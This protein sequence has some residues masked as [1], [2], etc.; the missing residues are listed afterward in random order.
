[1]PKRVKIT[2]NPFVKNRYFG[3]KIVK[4]F[5][6]L[7]FVFLVL[8]I[9]LSGCTGPKV[10]LI[11]HNGKVYTVDKPFSVM[12][13][14]AIRDGKIIATGTSTEI[15]H[16]YAATSIIDLEGKYVYPG[17]I[18]AHSHFFGYASD[19]LKCD[20]TGTRSYTELLEKLSLFSKENKFEWLLGRGWDQNDWEDTGYPD[21]TELDSLFPQQ[22]VFLM[23]IDG[24]AALCNSAALRRANITSSTKITGGEIVLKDG[25]PTGLLIDN[26]VDL[27]K[28]VIPP[29]S[30]ALNSDALLTAQENCFR[31]GLTSVCDAGLGKDSIELIRR[32]Q[33]KDR[34]KIRVYAMISD[35]KKSRDYYFKKGPILTDRLTVRAIKLYADGAL[36]SRG[37]LLKQPY[38]DQ[39]EH[40]GFLLHDVAYMNNLADEALEHGFQLCTHAIGDSAIRLMLDIFRE[41]LL[42]TNNRRWRLEHCQVVDPKD[43]GDFKKLSVIPSVQPTHATSDMYWAGSRLGDDRLKTAYCFKD[44]LKQSDRLA[45]GTDF[46]VERIDPLLT[47]YAA[48]ARKDTSGFP[49][50]GFLPENKIKRKDALR[51]M[52]IWAAY[53]NFEDLKKGSIEVGKYA[54]LV[55]LDQDILEC[56]EDQLLSTQVVA[57]YVDGE[58]LYRR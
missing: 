47:F 20:L 29:F 56:E 37:A 5:R 38:S 14:V 24:H 54:D 22:P 23:R 49:E 7:F 12:E 36:G 33:K 6:S 55:I 16:R 34:L 45:F 46:P 27:V 52:T 17:F 19:L 25:Q 9:V 58:L 39:P 51:A 10:D 28:E 35:T 2:N 11:L 32:L 15:L 57:T 40:Y 8:S 31:V 26:A 30:E 1:M 3:L 41:H 48:V 13:A 44:L 43:L 21:K 50:N 53:A 4:M 42:G 18:D